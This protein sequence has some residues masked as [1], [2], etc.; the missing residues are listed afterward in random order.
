M[1]TI[2]HCLNM[3]ECVQGWVGEKTRGCREI[4]EETIVKIEL[5]EKEIGII[6]EVLH[7]AWQSNAKKQD[8]KHSIVLEDLMGRL[9]HRGIF[10]SG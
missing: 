7:L 4:N 1:V 5:S 3:G 8:T 6:L 9:S 10:E 2:C